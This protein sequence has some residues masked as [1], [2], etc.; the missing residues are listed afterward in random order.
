MSTEERMLK[1]EA[2]LA[3]IERHLKLSATPVTGTPETNA[4][5]RP[6][7]GARAVAAPV[8][9]PA[10]VKALHAQL[11]S[12]PEATNHVTNFLGWAGATA[13]VLASIY[14]VSLA[15]DAGWLTPVRQVLLAMLGGI[16]CI[17][18]GFAL[19]NRDMHYASM[20]PGA[21][22]VIL[23]LSIYGAHNYYHLIAT[24]Y[25]TSGI[26][27]V[28]LLSLWLNRMF[29]SELYAMFAVLGSYTA[30]LFLGGTSYSMTDLIVYFAC[31]SVVF[32]IFSIWVGKRGVYVLAMYLA[33]V[34]FDYKWRFSVPDAW[35]EALVFQ[36]VHF[37]I[38]VAA[39]SLFSVRVRPMTQESSL[40]HIPALILFYSVQYHVLERHV[41]GLAPWVAIASAAVLLVS[42]FIVYRILQR[43]LE[44]GRTLLSTYV[45]LVLVHAGYI[46]SVPAQWAPWVG[47]LVIPLVGLYAALRGD[48]NSPG[49]PVWFVAG[50]VFVANYLKLF[51]GASMTSSFS[52]TP[53]HDLL[54]LCY[55]AELYLGYYFLRRTSGMKDV[56]KV[57][58]YAG[59]VAI[60]AW[61]IQIFDSRF[62][63]SLVWAILALGC[64][65]LALKVRDKTLGQSSLLV[66]AA[67][68]FKVFLYDIAMVSQLMRIASLLVLG[69]SL[70]LGGWLY[71]K[72]GNLEDQH[73]PKVRIG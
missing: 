60:M 19:R 4:A 46:E 61:A 6:E 14:L 49:M 43:E 64:L 56:D 10:H 15:I 42:Y 35:V 18:V 11:T 9:P 26:I 58:L 5:T 32:S 22:V 66:F 62:A 69:A 47:L 29:M 7:W 13:L 52:M 65:L 37:L 30:P 16:A 70:Y 68:I 73:E 34:I 20:L 54:A 39:A 41:P 1:I 2:R 45:A 38:F 12:E 59:H 17:G 23:F 67:S 48:V 72:V 53:G 36:T 71:K 25:A 44:G 3:A 50:L 27:I 24:T 21:G 8:S 55:A 57:V 63:V 31:W 40:A 33:F 28:C 51:V